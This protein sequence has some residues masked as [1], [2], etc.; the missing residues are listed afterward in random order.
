MKTA[1]VLEG[2]ALR[3]I[4]SSGV[5]D[6]FLDGELPLPDY[7]LGVSAGIA[8]G[9]SYLSRQSRR[10]LQLICHY[11]NDKRYMGFRNLADPRNRSYFGLRFAYETIPNELIP[12]DYDAFAAYPGRAEAVVTNLNTGEAEYLP[13]PRRDSPNLH[14]Q[15][16]CAIPLMFPIIRIGGQPYLDGGCA[17]AIPWRR[18]FH[19]GCDRVVVVLTRERDYYKK[20][21]R[22]DQAIGRAFKKYPYFQETMRTRSERY[23]A[24]REALFDLERQGRVLVIA[25]RDT[26]GC[27]RTEKNLD[28]LRRL[29]QEGYFDGRRE[30]ERVR[31]F[32][33]A[34]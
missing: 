25:P 3:T 23:N 20:P 19:E 28:T 2:G 31:E 1:L 7:T 10:N 27:S 12:F 5:C 4:Y 32:W 26:L 9:V 22:S 34:E 18:A 17:D 13:V 6:A 8:Y 16:T 24:C 14:L 15:A 21:G 30:I 33:T 11:A 29:W